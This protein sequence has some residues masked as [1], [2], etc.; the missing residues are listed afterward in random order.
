MYHFSQFI[1]TLSNIAETETQC[2]ETLNDVK[3]DA[4]ERFGMYPNNTETKIFC[5]LKEKSKI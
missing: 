3:I 4:S 2:I 5:N 1:K